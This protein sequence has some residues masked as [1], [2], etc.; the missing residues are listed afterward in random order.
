MGDQNSQ[1]KVDQREQ[2]V[3]CYQNFFGVRNDI[4]PERFEL[5]DLVSASNCDIDKSGRLA[6]RA[7]YTEVLAG[8]T[9]S[10]F[11]SDSLGL[12]M[13]VQGT[14]LLRIFPD[15]TTGVLKSG[16]TAG[17]RMTYTRVNNRV[18]FSN[19]FETGVVEN[20]AV[21]SWGLPVPPLP[22][23]VSTVGQMPTGWYQYVVT[24]FRSDGQES[25]AGLA[26][27]IN[28]GGGLAF[29]VPASTDPD[30]V[31]KGIYVTTQN[32]D[33]LY[34]AMVIPN[35]TTSAIYNNNTRE[36][37]VPLLTQF[38]TPPPAGQVTGYYKGRMFVGAGDVLYPSEPFGF[39]LF[40]QR[41]YIQT[42]GKLTM[43]APFE[44][45]ESTD[46]ATKSGLFLG[47]D[48]SCGVLVGADPDTFRYVTKTG[49]GAVQGAL[50]YVDGSLFGDNS[51][52]AR[53]LPM[54]LTTQ[55][56]CVGMADMEIKNLTRTRYG[57][58]I[59]NQGAA[60]FIPGPNRYIAV[61]SS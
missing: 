59:G 61:S 34:L 40:D 30:V 6:R 3:V 11:G 35:A 13:C 53:S 19:G 31:S 16:L 46:I 28:C 4:D 51:S 32:G 8:T 26:G 36:L 54:W 48:K 25:G 2:D 57:F 52:N 37:T 33:A 38:L 20:G 1:Q 29:T 43:I 7:G 56:V 41:K 24:Y 15:Y 23:V 12:A 10:I 39:E 55:G 42:D 60:I 45:K 9:H 58:T 18:Y 5:G 47:T 50:D 27:K 17:Q 44:D 22:T 21:R 14:Q 49:Y